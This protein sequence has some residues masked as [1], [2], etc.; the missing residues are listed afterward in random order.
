MALLYCTGNWLCTHKSSLRLDNGNSYGE[1]RD[2]HSLASDRTIFTAARTRLQVLVREFRRDGNLL[3]H[4]T[5]PRRADG[6]MFFMPH[7]LHGLAYSQC[8]IIVEHAFV[9]QWNIQ[10][11]AGFSSSSTAFCA[12]TQWEET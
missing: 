11:F 2:R 1:A 6:N 10:R 9:W 3:K 12:Y 8:E 5:S 7:R 4:A